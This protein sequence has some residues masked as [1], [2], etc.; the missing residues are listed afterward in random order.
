[1]TIRNW[2]PAFCAVFCAG[3]VVSA[4]ISAS[5]RQNVGKPE[6]APFIVPPVLFGWEDGDSDHAPDILRD[7]R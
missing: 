6:Y 3:A 5:V 7:L 1:M 4:Q 2:P